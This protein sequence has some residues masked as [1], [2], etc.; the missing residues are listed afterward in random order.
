MTVHKQDLRHQ[1]AD[2]QIRKSFIL[3]LR[4]FPFEKIT[5]TMLVN[6]ARLSRRTFYNHFLDK[7]DLLE[8]MQATVLAELKELQKSDQIPEVQN[9][10]DQKLTQAAIF[11]LQ[12]FLKYV[13]QNREIICVL[14]K[15]QTFFFQL[16]DLIWQIL[17]QRITS[18]GASLNPDIPIEYVKSILVDN[19]ADLIFIW[20]AKKHPEPLTEFTQILSYSRLHAP[21]ELL[22]FSEHP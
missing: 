6:K 14:L 13:D 7:Y 10:N 17:S 3:L 1:R 12:H 22:N 5:T 19:L 18:Y 9:F 20:I 2:Y 16:K 11:S 8:Q 15:D 21:L 4:E